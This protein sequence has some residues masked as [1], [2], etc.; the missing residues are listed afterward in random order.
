MKGV[1][2][3]EYLL[4]MCS[5]YLHVMVTFEKL[6][7]VLMELNY[8]YFLFKVNI[9]YVFFEKCFSISGS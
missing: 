6:L 9:F 8:Q 7:L 5:L 1:I 2:Y 3:V 4:K